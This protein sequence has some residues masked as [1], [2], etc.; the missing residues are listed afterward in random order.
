MKTKTQRLRLALLAVVLVLAG[1]GLYRGLIAKAPP[2]VEVAAA[3]STPTA[4]LPR[5]VEIGSDSCATCI[6]MQQVVADLR[7]HHA[8]RLEVVSINLRQYPEQVKVWKV[9][10]IPTQVFLDGQGRELYRHVGYLPRPAVE[11][12]FAALGFPLTAAATPASGS[13]R[14]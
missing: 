14:E 1:A 13:V 7:T 4:G 5:M 6:A 10:F 12:R 3:P 9:K 2:A 11:E 8:D